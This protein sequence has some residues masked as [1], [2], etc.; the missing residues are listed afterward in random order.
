[1]ESILQEQPVIKKRV[2]WLRYYLRTTFLWLIVVPAL[3]LTGGRGKFTVSDP[4]EP[5]IA[6]NNM[7]FACWEAF[8]IICLRAS[9]IPGL[10]R[11]GW[12]LSEFG[13]VYMILQGT[14]IIVANL[15]NPATTSSVYLVSGGYFIVLGLIFMF[16]RWPNPILALGRGCYRLPTFFKQLPSKIAK[17]E[18]KVPT[19]WALVV[20]VIFTFV[21][22]LLQPG[23][24]LAF[25]W[26]PYAD[27]AQLTPKESVIVPFFVPA[28]IFLY[29]FCYRLY[30]PEC[31]LFTEFISLMGYFHGFAMMTD[32]I[33]GTQGNTN[34]HHI[35]GGDVVLMWLIGSVFLAY[36]PAVGQIQSFSGTTEI[37]D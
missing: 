8:A 17:S 16:L 22:F 7:V 28:A 1:M 26:F 6:T 21:Y 24:G 18:H 19:Y 25:R 23:I 34:I 37:S 2:R 12:C 4:T 5:H 20:A 30:D 29:R 33:A 32:S 9:F 11:Y 3:C 36:H 13:A 15:A 14:I 31:I 27:P 10:D 35:Y